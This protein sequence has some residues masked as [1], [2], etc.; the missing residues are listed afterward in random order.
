MP[1]LPS[2][3]DRADGTTFYPAYTIDGVV[4]WPEGYI[5]TAPA[6]GQ[7]KVQTAG[8]GD[9]LTDIP[10]EEPDSPEIERAEQATITHRFTMEWN[11][12]LMRLQ[13]LGRGTFLY[14]QNGNTSRVLSAT[15]RYQKPGLGYLTVVAE[16]INFDTPW[17]E[18]QIIPVELGINI[19]KHPR[20]LYA[21]LGTSTAEEQA[22]QCVIRIL[23]D[24]MENPNAATRDAAIRL[25]KSSL[26]SPNGDGTAVQPPTA[27]PGQS[28]YE[29][30]YPAGSLVAGTEMA[31]RAALEIITKYWRNT[32][33]PYIVGWQ[34]VYSQ[35]F[36][37]PPS[38]NPGGYLEDPIL[39]DTTPLP[40]FFWNPHW[41]DLSS[42]TIFDRIIE[43][44]PQCYS[45]DGTNQG[46]LNISWLRKSDQVE[47]QRTWFKRTSTWCGSAVGYWDEELFTSGPRPQVPDDYLPVHVGATSL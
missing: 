17:D 40:D 38:I 16:S 12:A 39:N 5:G 9:E 45:S 42:D 34:I 47:H 21:F 4:I 11:E 29:D 23:Q 10:I 8:G 3:F 25:L 36:W 35:Y 44:N 22:N 19:I 31:K 15:V 7:I 6:A 18:F 43:F 14:D 33:T 20:Y 1:A 2:G 13:W 30:V 28:S 24:Y 27:K 41:P 26:N 32:E 46:T 37:A